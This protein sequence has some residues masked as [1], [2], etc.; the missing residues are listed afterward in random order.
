MFD[1]LFFHLLLQK[2]IEDIPKFAELYIFMSLFDPTVKVYSLSSFKLR[3]DIFT[4]SRD[5]V[6]VF[7]EK[8]LVRLQHKFEVFLVQLKFQGVIEDHEHD[9]G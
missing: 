3:Y 9:D 8:G 2:D 7:F 1:K 4:I 6:E 5:I